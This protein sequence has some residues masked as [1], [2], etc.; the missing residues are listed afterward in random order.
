MVWTFES[1]SPATYNTG[2]WSGTWSA[3]DGCGGGYKQ[4]EWLHC[5]G[6]LAYNQGA[7]AT[8]PPNVTP[9]TI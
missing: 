8:P 3:T 4:S 5:N 1:E 6:Y 9:T 7:T 2:A